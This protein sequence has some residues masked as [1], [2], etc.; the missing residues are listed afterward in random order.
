[1]DPPFASTFAWLISIVPSTAP[2]DAANASIAAAT[3]NSA[4]G[5]FRFTAR[6][7][8]RRWRSLRRWRP[9]QSAALA[10]PRRIVP[11]R[12]QN[13][14]F[15]GSG[16]FVTDAPH[17]SQITVRKKITYDWAVA[18]AAQYQDPLAREASIKTLAG[19]APANGGRGPNTGCRGHPCPRRCGT[20]GGFRI[21]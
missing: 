6:F 2:D 10:F 3:K 15:A 18:T 4:A 11:G 9:H 16:P 12:P 21:Q 20:H 17:L 19:A 13:G 8:L 5:S 1:G 14:P 7:L